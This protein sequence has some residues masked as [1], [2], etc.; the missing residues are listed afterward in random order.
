MPY[1]AGGLGVRRSKAFPEGERHLAKAN[2]RDEPHIADLIP[3][4]SSVALTGT[5]ERVPEIFAGLA[6]LGVTELV[7]QPAGSDI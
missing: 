5:A 6:A 4:A 1:W 7:Y 2:P 3:F